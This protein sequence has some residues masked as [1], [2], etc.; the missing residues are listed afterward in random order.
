MYF[1][2]GGGGHN[3]PAMAH[4]DRFLIMVTHQRPS[5]NAPN[6]GLVT[7]T[8]AKRVQRQTSEV[9]SSSSPFNFVHRAMH[10]SD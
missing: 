2:E 9:Q 1:W 5:G 3:S 7:W 4:G 6:I 10:L 8:G